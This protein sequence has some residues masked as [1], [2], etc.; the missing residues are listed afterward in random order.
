ML[1][2]KSKARSWRKYRTKSLSF[3]EAIKEEFLDTLIAYTVDSAA[4]I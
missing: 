1:P 4:V 2:A 3:K